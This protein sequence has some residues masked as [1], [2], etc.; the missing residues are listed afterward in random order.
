MPT[1]SSLSRVNPSNTGTTAQKL[2]NDLLRGLYDQDCLA[3]HSISGLINS[4]KGPS[5]P[6]LPEDQI[7][8]ILREVQHY[9]PGKTDSE[10]KGYISQKL[11]NESKRLRKKPLPLSTKEEEQCRMAS[12]VKSTVKG[13]VAVVNVSAT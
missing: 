9:F 2:T 3:S 7:Q 5:K 1:V 8:A 11:Q 4:K 6:A 13:V 12:M 10:I